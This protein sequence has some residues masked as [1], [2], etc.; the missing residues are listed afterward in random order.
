MQL[1]IYHVRN[2]FLFESRVIMRVLSR[3][4]TSLPNIVY[5]NATHDFGIGVDEFN[6]FTDLC[7]LMYGLQPLNERDVTCHLVRRDIKGI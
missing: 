2:S 5:L 6:I 4:T 1:V 3:F 7:S